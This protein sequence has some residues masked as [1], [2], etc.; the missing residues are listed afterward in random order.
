MRSGERAELFVKSFEHGEVPQ[1]WGCNGRDSPNLGSA[2]IPVVLRRGFDCAL[3][4]LGGGRNG[5]GRSH[6]PV[7]R[8]FLAAGRG[9][10]NASATAAWPKGRELSADKRGESAV[11]SGAA[12]LAASLRRRADPAG[13]HDGVS[14]PA[15]ARNRML[16]ITLTNSADGNLASFSS[17]AS[18]QL[19][20]FRWL[21]GLSGGTR[22]LA[23]GC[24]WLFE[25]WCFDR[26]NEIP[27]YSLAPDEHVVLA[28]GLHRGRHRA[29]GVQ[30]RSGPC[31]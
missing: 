28:F 27:R 29:V 8:H 5:R 24:G 14:A 11:R 19:C 20:E 10:G 26:N 13:D 7:L 30:C 4:Q 25:D 16:L 31:I 18:S 12:L 23:L 1:K 3:L 22:M 15:R 6:L 9:R 17:P 21:G 2:L